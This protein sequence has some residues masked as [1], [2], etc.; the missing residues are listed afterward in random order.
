MSRIVFTALT[1]AVIGAASF[2]P[3]PGHAQAPEESAKAKAAVQPPSDGAASGAMASPAAPV[4]A[5]KAS[6]ERSPIDPSGGK[7]SLT[8]PIAAATR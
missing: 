1:V 5:G 2:A 6:A 4:K 8:K 3:A 7:A